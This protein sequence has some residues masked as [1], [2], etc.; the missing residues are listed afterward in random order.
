MCWGILLKHFELLTE[1]VSRPVALIFDPLQ[2]K[3]RK[4]NTRHMFHHLKVPSAV[5]HSPSCVPS[6]PSQLLVFTL[7]FSHFPSGHLSAGPGL[8]G[9]PDH[10]RNELPC[11]QGGHPQRPRCSELRVSGNNCPRWFPL[12]SRFFFLWFFLVGECLSPPFLPPDSI[13]DNMQVKITDNALARD[14]FPMDYHCLG[15]NENRPVRWMALESLLN[16]DFSSASDVVRNPLAGTAFPVLRVLVYFQETQGWKGPS[17]KRDQLC[18]GHS[19]DSCS[20]L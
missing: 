17:R 18:S 20:W 9:H 4:F 19:F 3:R 14:L 1:A 13:D 5:L 15:D 16:N 12:C 2:K 10:V 11:S 7:R 6:P 8:H